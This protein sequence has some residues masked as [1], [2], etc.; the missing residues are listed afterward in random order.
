[1]FRN[2]MTEQFDWKRYQLLLYSVGVGL[3]AF[4]AR[5][6]IDAGLGTD[7]L[8]VLVIGMN[9]HLSIGLGLCSS[10]VAGFFLAW[11]TL[12][13]RRLPPL[14]PFVTTAVVGFMLDYFGAINIRQYTVDAIPSIPLSL[15][16]EQYDLARFIAVIGALLLCSYA[17]ALIIMSGIGIRI[18]DLVAITMI[19]RLGW[20]FFRA[21]MTLE[22]GLFTL[23]WLLGGPVG[24]TTLLFLVFVGPFIQ[25]FMTV[26]NAYLG[27]PNRGIRYR[28]TT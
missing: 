12:W 7:P 23:G 27:I 4:G 10:L 6:F 25:P 11:W 20:D 1:M 26:N 28:R 19:E 2:F 24:I 21:K 9:G 13:N 3:F 18:M 15:A 17:S 5:V 14:S 16:G 8:D 22:I